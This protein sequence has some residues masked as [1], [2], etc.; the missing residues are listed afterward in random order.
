MMIIIIIM[1]TINVIISKRLLAISFFS[2]TMCLKKGHEFRVRANTQ[3]TETA[4]A[5]ALLRSESA[6]VGSSERVCLSPAH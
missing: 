1:I 4:R 2:S 3:Q 6:R 5:P